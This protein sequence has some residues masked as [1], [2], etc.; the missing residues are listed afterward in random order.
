MGAS[1]IELQWAAIQQLGAAKE[2]KKL[3]R[4]DILVVVGVIPPQDFEALVE[5]GAVAIYPPGTVITE[6]TIELLEKLA[7]ALGIAP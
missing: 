4:E 1:L 3:R 7:R 6:A 5:A 2:Q